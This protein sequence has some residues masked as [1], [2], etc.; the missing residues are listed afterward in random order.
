MENRPPRKTD[1]GNNSDF[2]MVR[3]R[4]KLHGFWNTP[5][6]RQL[7][8]RRIA[9]KKEF[10]SSRVFRGLRGINQERRDNSPLLCTVGGQTVKKANGLA[11]RTTRDQYL[12][13]TTRRRTG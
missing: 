3:S 8:C 7:S 11:R 13:Y 2:F 5:K 4:P 10:N 1:A 9:R 6:T 12:S